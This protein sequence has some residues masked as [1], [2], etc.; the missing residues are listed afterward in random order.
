MPRKIEN[1]IY[2]LQKDFAWGS[3]LFVYRFKTFM[4]FDVCKKGF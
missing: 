3:S 2:G 4:K 1:F